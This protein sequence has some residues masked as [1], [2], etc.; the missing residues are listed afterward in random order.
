[1]NLNS[2]EKSPDS[3][4]CLSAGV[5]NVDTKIS[6]QSNSHNDSKKDEDMIVV[7]DPATTTTTTATSATSATITTGKTGTRARSSSTSCINMDVDHP[8]STPPL[9]SP[10]KE[11][12]TLATGTPVK[13]KAPLTTTP[14]AVMKKPTKPPQRQTARQRTPVV[15]IQHQYTEM[16]DPMNNMG[17]SK[18]RKTNTEA[19][20]T[21]NNLSPSTSTGLDSRSSSTKR[22]KK[23]KLSPKNYTKVTATKKKQTQTMDEDEYPSTNHTDNYSNQSSSNQENTDSSINTLS[24]NKRETLSCKNTTSSKTTTKIGP[25]ARSSSVN[26]STNSTNNHHDNKAR[27]YRRRPPTY[28]WIGAPY[29]KLPSREDPT[30]T[31]YNYRKLEIKVGNHCSFISVG[32]SVLLCSGD[33]EEDE[34]YGGPLLPANAA[35]HHQHQPEVTTNNINYSDSHP[36]KVKEQKSHTEQKNKNK[37]NNSSKLIVENNHGTEITNGETKKKNVHTT[38]SGNETIKDE[39]ESILGLVAGDIAIN[40][41]DP[42]VAKIDSMWEEW[43]ASKSK[44]K[45]NDDKGNDNSSS[46]TTTSHKNSKKQKC[47]NSDSEPEMIYHD[48]SRTRMKFRARWYFKVRRLQYFFYSTEKMNSKLICHITVYCSS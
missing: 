40:A 20:T 42:F 19:T 22:P 33:M 4:I 25:A 44:E 23:P 27:L 34:L 14:T 15:R 13:E 21:T 8:P 6:S 41:L 5:R 24:Q 38:A 9:K 43:P 30:K 32:D 46:S 2:T 17:S 18:K 1:M 47:N 29:S 7:S 39:N 26:V 48:E 37:H 3:S 16:Y 35:D 10:K 45:N 36:T 28:R 31:K 12:E 11:G